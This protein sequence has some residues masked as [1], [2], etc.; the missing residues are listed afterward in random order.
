MDK[1]A[2]VARSQRLNS[3]IATVLQKRSRHAM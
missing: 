3:R 1:D 2:W